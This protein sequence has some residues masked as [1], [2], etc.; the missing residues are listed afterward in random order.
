MF[1]QEFIELLNARLKIYQYFEGY[2]I[3]AVKFLV[4]FLKEALCSHFFII[5]KCQFISEQY[6][7]FSVVCLVLIN[8]FAC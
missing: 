4:T 8:K 3:L 7:N 6:I 5:W 2:K 1:A